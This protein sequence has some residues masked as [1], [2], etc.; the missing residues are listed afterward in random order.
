MTLTGRHTC[1]VTAAYG[2]WRIH[3]VSMSQYVYINLPDLVL[4]KEPVELSL[5]DIAWKGK[6][7]PGKFKGENCICCQGVRYLD[8]DTSYPGIVVEGIN[9]PYKLPYRLIDGKHRVQ[10]LRD[11]GEK[12]G[13]FYVLTKDQVMGYTTTTEKTK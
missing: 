6:H 9:N 7:L 1:K 10:R 13:L 3:E 12:T 4:P 2:D 11:S 5:F 8:C